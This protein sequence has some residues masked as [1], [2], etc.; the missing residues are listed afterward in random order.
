MGESYE[1]AVK[2][3][4][5]ELAA[6]TAKQETA[7]QRRLRELQED[8]DFERLKAKASAEVR[9]ARFLIE[10]GGQVVFRQFTLGEV[11]AIEVADEKPEM[12]AEQASAAR[13]MVTLATV[14][15]A[16]I[17]PA[18]PEYDRLT[19]LYPLL[20]GEIVQAMNA[21]N[22]AYRRERLGK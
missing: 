17:S 11:R 22:H 10:G 9:L 7:E 12:T 15:K 4:E 8:V 18:L 6:L 14:R 19:S 5:A 2:R 21:H 3:L 16:L 13:K 20:D 1:E